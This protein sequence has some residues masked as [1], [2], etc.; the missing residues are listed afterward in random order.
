MGG[1]E[2]NKIIKTAYKAA[3]NSPTY[4][5]SDKGMGLSL[6]KCMLFF[7]PCAEIDELISRP[8]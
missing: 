2:K 6:I 8:S 3:A 5:P 4:R 7:R 1:V